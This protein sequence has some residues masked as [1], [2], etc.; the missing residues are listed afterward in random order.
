MGL[1]TN[2][3]DYVNTLDNIICKALYL[4]NRYAKTNQ[5]VYNLQ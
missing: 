4:W 5:I 2:N 3:N 1:I